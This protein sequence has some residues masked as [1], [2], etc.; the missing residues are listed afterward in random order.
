MPWPAFIFVGL[1]AA[2]GMRLVAWFDPA[3]KISLGART[4]MGAVVG[5]VI[6]GYAVLVIALLTRSLLAAI[7]ISGIIMAGFL[8]VATVNAWR[9]RS[10]WSAGNVLVGVRRAM[11]S[12]W[13][14]LM[15]AVLGVVVALTVQVLLPEPPFVAGILVGWGDVAL[16]LG[17]TERLAVA[18]PFILEHPAF[19]GHS[20]SYS[21]LVNFL[22]AIY[23]RLGAPVLVAFHLPAL[24]FVVSAVLL[25]WVFFRQLVGRQGLALLMV[26]LVL[27]G[28]GLG[29]WWLGADLGTAYQAGGITAAWETLGDLPH[30]YT[31]LDL[32]TGGAPAEKQAGHNIVWI[33][34]VLS[35]LTHQRSFPVGL[36]LG[37]LVLLGVLHYGGQYSLA[38]YGVLAGLLPLAHGHTFLALAILF[39][40]LIAV[41]PRRLWSYA[42]FGAVTLAVATPSL[43]YLRG[44]ISGATGG[45]FVAWW[46]GWMTCAHATHW[47]I[48]DQPP[49]A[50]VDTSATWFWLKNFGGVVAAWALVG[51]YQLVSV[52]ARWRSQTTAAVIVPLLLPSLLLFAVPNLVRLQPWEFDNNKVLFWWWILAVGIIGQALVAVPRRWRLAFA[53]ILALIV[54]PAGGADV[55]MRLTHFRAN[56]FGYVGQSEVAAAEWIRAHVPPNAR[57]VGSTSPNHFVPILTGRALALGFEGWLWTEGVDYADRRSAIAALARGDSTGVCAAGFDYL[58]DDAD[59]R[60]AFTA[61]PEALARV[62]KPLWQ[63]ETPAGTRTIGRITCPP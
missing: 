28:G 23:R 39:V 57:I 55:A 62:V 30:E 33:V 17:M 18:S 5:M 25:L 13:N 1:Q 16:H 51:S 46:W 15:A 22:S 8:G 38:R 61:E 6:S 32:R 31:H 44:A 48:C 45:S 3:R 49:A 34:P 52:M 14:W 37:L 35:F 21:F 29:W 59:F 24:I 26:S 63:Q 2:F 42:A 40:G 4:V 10:R 60:S 53:G 43:L 19:A 47:F 27:F 41:Q 54:L 50:G 58:V 36:A 20:L 9:G 7:F 11:V 12:P 56:H